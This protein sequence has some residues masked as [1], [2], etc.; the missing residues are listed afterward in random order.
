MNKIF[1]MLDG[2]KC[3]GKW[4]KE[5]LGGMGSCDERVMQ[6]QIEWSEK[7]WPRGQCLCQCLEDI[8][9]DVGRWAFL[10]E[11]TVLTYILKGSHWLL[12]WEYAEGNQKLNQGHQWESFQV[13][14]YLGLG[15]NDLNGGDDEKWSSTRSLEGRAVRIWDMRKDESIVIPRFLSRAVFRW[16]RLK[17]R[18]SLLDWELG[19]CVWRMRPS[20]SISRRQMDM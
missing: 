1:S 17:E 13:G 2:D 12:C 7:A 4:V 8:G 6:F 18:A 20:Q 10:A 9:V 16:K 11:G 14:D 3:H 15:R 5:G 19:L